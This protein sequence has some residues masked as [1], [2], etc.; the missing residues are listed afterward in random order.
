VKPRKGLRDE[1]LNRNTAP[2]GKVYDPSGIEIKPGDPWQLGHVPGEKFT[3]SQERAYYDGWDSQTW[4]DYQNDPDIYR[5]ELPW[6]NVSHLY[7]T[8]W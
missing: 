4:R 8:R 5:P 6:S 1:V 2:N 3:D 7:E